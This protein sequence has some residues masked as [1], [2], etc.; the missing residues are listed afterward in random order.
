MFDCPLACIS[1]TT[2]KLGKWM[3]AEGYDV[4]ESEMIRDT[5]RLFDPDRDVE[6][7]VT[8]QIDS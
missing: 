7:S 5:K 4:H 8:S 2:F 6:L 1:A 3:K